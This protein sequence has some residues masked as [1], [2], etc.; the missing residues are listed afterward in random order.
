[1]L[2]SLKFIRWLFIFEH[3]INTSWIEAVAFLKLIYDVFNREFWTQLVPLN[4][5]CSDGIIAAG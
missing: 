3:L 1:M 5:G 4:F 2:R